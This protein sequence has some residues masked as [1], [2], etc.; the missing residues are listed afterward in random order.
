MIVHILGVQ[1]TLW[2]ASGRHHFPDCYIEDGVDLIYS[3][4][5]S[6]Y[7]AGVLGIIRGMSCRRNFTNAEVNC[8]GRGSDISKRVPWE[9]KLDAQQINPFSKSSFIDQDGWLAKLPP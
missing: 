6:F 8:R 4:G 1:D 5:Q 3:V 2:D 9:K 7:E